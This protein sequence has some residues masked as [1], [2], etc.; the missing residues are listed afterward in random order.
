MNNALKLLTQ[1]LNG[2]APNILKAIIIVVVGMIAAR[3]IGRMVCKGLSR[4]RLDPTVHRFLCHIVKIATQIVV[5]ITAAGMIGIPITTFV[6]VLGGAA[7]AV[8]LALQNSLSNVASG[9]LLLFNRPFR[10]GDYIEVDDNGG[11]V[12][13]ISLMS[14]SLLTPDN[15]RVIVPNSTLTNKTLINYSTEAFRRVDFTFA[16]SFDSDIALAKRVLSDIADQHPLCLKEP[17]LRIAV[18]SLND[19]GVNLIAQLWCERGEYWNL[20]FDFNEKV[21]QAFA[22]NGILLPYPQVYIHTQ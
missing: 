8:S 21:R 7:V 1:W 9:L 22:E 4:S 6:T 13:A 18:R 11:T 5:L 14:T 15:K 17:K 20:L 2:S 3:Y 16:V 12:D 10:V 19:T